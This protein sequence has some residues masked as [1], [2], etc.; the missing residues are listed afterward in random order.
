MY[1]FVCNQCGKIKEVEYKGKVGLY[2]SRKCADLAKKKDGIVIHDDGYDW[3]VI[4][5]GNH[6]YFEC[7]YNNMVG[8][9]TRNCEQCGWNPKVANERLEKIRAEMAGGADTDELTV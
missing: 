1:Q 2:C 7:R 6:P 3:K 9:D 4:R 8:C 5:Q